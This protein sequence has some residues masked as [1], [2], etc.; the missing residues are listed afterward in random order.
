[1]GRIIR[2]WATYTNGAQGTAESDRGL[3]VVLGKMYQEALD[4]TG[5]NHA[6]AEQKL[7]QSIDNDR[8]FDQYLTAPLVDR[9]R[10]CYKTGAFLDFTDPVLKGGQPRPC[11]LRG[12][13]Y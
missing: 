1:M 12:S 8:R 10:D 3:R 13:R 6:N 5:G 7:A 4:T 2:D 9:F 11:Q